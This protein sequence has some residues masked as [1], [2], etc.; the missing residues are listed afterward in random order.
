MILESG[1]PNLLRMLLKHK[2]NSWHSAALLRCE[3]RQICA[4]ITGKYQLYVLPLRSVWDPK[5]DC[6]LTHTH[7]HILA[8]SLEWKLLIELHAEYFVVFIVVAA[9][10]C[11]MRLRDC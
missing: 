2:A 7:T 3:S 1:A 4:N 11:G 10:D 8:H 9:T 5:A 6:L